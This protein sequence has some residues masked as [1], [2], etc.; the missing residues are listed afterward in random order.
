MYVFIFLAAILIPYP[1]TISVLMI[2]VG[3]TWWV[4]IGAGI[5]AAYGL[6]DAVLD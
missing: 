2:M 5:I 4:A 3:S 6:C 1:F